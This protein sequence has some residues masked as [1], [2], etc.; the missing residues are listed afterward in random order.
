MDMAERLLKSFP[1]YNKANEAYIAS[2]VQTLAALPNDIVVAIMD[3]TTGIR[4]KCQF[5]PTVAD[6]C[7]FAV[8]YHKQQD[9]FK[10]IRNAPEHKLLAR[11]NSPKPTIE[12]RQRAKDHWEKVKEEITAKR[13]AE[14]EAQ[15]SKIGLGEDNRMPEGS[16]TYRRRQ[17]F[18]TGP[19][20]KPIQIRGDR[21]GKELLELSLRE[22]KLKSPFWPNN[23]TEPELSPYIPPRGRRDIPF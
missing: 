11:D 23:L 15:R 21:T 4:S 9:Q 8:E 13:L 10:P 14:I 18:V 1:D 7:N 2:I 6:L 16:R 3:L 17:K 19:D 5:L 22:D 20:G 12:E